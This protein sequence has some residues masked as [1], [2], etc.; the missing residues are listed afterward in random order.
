[1][2]TTPAEDRRFGE[3]GGCRQKQKRRDADQC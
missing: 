1:V 3:C 2:L